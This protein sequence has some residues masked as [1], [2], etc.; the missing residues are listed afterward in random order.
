MV[1]DAQ[2]N[3]IL[4][5][6]VILNY[7]T[8]DKLTVCLDSISRNLRNIN[9]ETIVIENGS[10]DNSAE[11]IRENYPWVKLIENTKN[12]FFA[13][14]NNQGFA[15]ARGRY[16]L[17]LNSDTEIIGDVIQR[18][19]AYM[20]QPDN[21]TVGACTCRIYYPDGVLHTF[22]RHNPGLFIFIARHLFLEK[23][24]FKKFFP[25][26]FKKIY[27]KTYYSE[28]NDQPEERDILMGIAVLF[29]K[30]VL[31]EIGGFNEK[32]KLYFTDDEICHRITKKG[33]KLMSLPYEKIIHHHSVSISR[34]SGANKILDEDAIVYL[35][36][37]MNYL[38]FLIA[39]AIYK[40]DR[41]IT[42]KYLESKRSEKPNEI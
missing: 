38:S 20:E 30:K 1:I 28:D 14:G 13:A 33:Y 37:K 6:I 11:I 15:V 32:Y 35:K 17:M 5:S 4:I 19:L 25:N 29:R 2:N 10:G 42:G 31:D 9:S 7:K 8:I 27:M 36:D 41:F 24:Y 22:N 26:L 40:A 23:R 18:M 16:V 39:A 34:L 21:K 3:D 12:R